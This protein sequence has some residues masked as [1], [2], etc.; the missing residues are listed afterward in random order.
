MY[1]YCPSR[2]PRKATGGPWETTGRGQ[3]PR[4]DFGP[5]HGFHSLTIPPGPLKLRL[6]EEFGRKRKCACFEFGS[7]R[8]CC[9]KYIPLHNLR[10]PMALKRM[11][12]HLFLNVIHTSLLRY[13]WIAYWGY[14]SW[15][16]GGAIL[17]IYSTCMEG[18][19]LGVA[20]IPQF[21][22][23]PVWFLPMPRARSVRRL[24]AACKTVLAW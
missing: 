23:V 1:I 5:A 2:R 8:A 9:C 3:F 24:D 7:N 17:M 4:T 15:P 20:M 16:H 22:S 18:A 10:P 11:K 12:T 14:G 21:S 13:F 6:F 19:D